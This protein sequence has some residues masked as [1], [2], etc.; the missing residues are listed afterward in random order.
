MAA[1]KGNQYAK[2]RKNVKGG[3]PKGH[4]YAKGRAPKTPSPFDGRPPEY[5]PEYYAEKIQEW[6]TKDSSWNIAGFCSEY[7]LYPEL[8][9]NFCE[10]SKN[11][12]SVYNKI[13][14]KL[15]EKREKLVSLGKLHN[16]SYD[17]YQPM[18]DKFL[19]DYE[20]E[21]LDRA[22]ERQKK[23]AEN[24]VDALKEVLDKIDNTTKDLVE[25]TKKDESSRESSESPSESSLENQ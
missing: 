10:R 16:K 21:K 12:L 23:A 8:I 11:F 22:A 17:R 18:Y 4:Q 9:Y 5:D 1:P 7:D 6:V 15:A 3:A 19:H 14:I 20:E 13:K 25:H 24:T 2:G